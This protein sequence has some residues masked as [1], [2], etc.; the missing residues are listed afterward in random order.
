MICAKRPLKRYEIQWAFCRD[1]TDEDEQLPDVESNGLM[2][3]VKELCG[4]LIR[5]LPG[6]RLELVHNTARRYEIS[7]TYFQRRFG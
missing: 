4:T 2:M 5:E 6:E 7:S 3:K 1:W